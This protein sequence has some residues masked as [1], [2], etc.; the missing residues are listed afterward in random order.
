MSADKIDQVP[1]VAGVRD[2]VRSDLVAF[3]RA[4]RH[5]GVDV[6]ANAAAVAA[7][8]LVEVG[9][10]DE[11][12]VRAALKAALVGRPEDVDRFDRLFATFWR[13]LT[14]RLS[15][16]EGDRSALEAN[17]DER[18]DEHLA[19]L[20]AEDA[21]EADGVE[22]DEADPTLGSETWTGGVGA[23][24]TEDGDE[25]VAKATYSPAGQPEQVIV[26]LAPTSGDGELMRTV[27]QFV[28]A[29][30]TERGRQW[31]PTRSGE[32]ADVRR[33]LRKSIATGGAIVSV[34]ERRRARTAS[35][36]LVLT[37]V[38]RSILDVI[39]RAFL[40]RWL[41]TLQAR[42]RNCRT[43]LFDN[44]IREV[45]DAFD[46]GDTHVA[47]KALRDAETA[48]GG[49]TRIGNAVTTIRNDYAET[50][51]RRTTVLIVS[52]GLE[53]GDVSSLESGMAWLSRRA[54]TVLWLNPLAA[55]P[56]YEPSAAGIAAALPAIDGLF[57]FTGPDDVSE[58]A[59]QLSRYGSRGAI[60]YEHD[61]RRKTRDQL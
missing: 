23:G 11:N 37:D 45:T 18:S 34:P 33:S 12:R 36:V 19:P 43:F 50:V 56:D 27:E 21:P 28:R 51:D 47:V 20:S 25:T 55:T 52:D 13:R 59:R 58:M 35:R 30:A 26:R 3:T 53:M 10:D 44:E 24:D 8:A 5:A 31:Q 49:G 22:A 41:R 16:A 29:I 6:S 46:A 39:D 7:R 61:P 14:D 4:L 42:T 57:A 15:L 2:D 1:D 48:W 9:F 54:A 40:L 32:K 17:D 38:S 60:G